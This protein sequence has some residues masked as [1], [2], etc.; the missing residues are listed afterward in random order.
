MIIRFLRRFP[1]ALAGVWYG[2]TRDLSFATQFFGGIVVNICL[3][4]FASPLSSIE[5]LFL[6]LGW[7]LVLI[8]ELQNSAIEAALD[9]LHPER[10]EAIMRSKDMAAGAVLIAAVFFAVIVFTIVVT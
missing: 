2:V 8:T 6:L 10:H 3:L 7:I 5:L 1:P 4:V 9:Q